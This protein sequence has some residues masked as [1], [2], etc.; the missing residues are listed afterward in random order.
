MKIELSLRYAVIGFYLD[1]DRSI[2]RV[3]PLPFVRI[4]LGPRQ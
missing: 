1:R 4:S 3:Y 2:L